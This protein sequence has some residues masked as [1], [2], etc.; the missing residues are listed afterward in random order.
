MGRIVFV[1]YD[2]KEEAS[3]F[4]AELIT[5]I[6]GLLPASKT[7]VLG[8]AT[9]QSPVLTYQEIAKIVNR[10]GH[11]WPKI[12]DTIEFWQLDTYV[13]PG[14]TEDNL[15]PYSYE[16]ELAA[17]IWKVPN[18]GC[19]IPREWAEDPESE[20]LRYA[21]EIAE[22]I[23]RVYYTFQVLG[24]GDEDGHIAF[25]MP[26]DSFKSKTHRVKL[27]KETIYANAHKFFGGDEEKV[28]KYAITTGIGEIL[29]SNAIILEAF[30]KKKANI[31]WKSFFTDPTTD[32]PATAL[33]LF[34][35]DLV[36]LLDEEAAS[37]IVEKEGE[38]VFTKCALNET[39]VEKF[40]FEYFC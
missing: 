39:D 22:R 7:K 23:R 8:T 16:R 33:Q 38:G 14:S 6:F 4:A 34:K 32:I 3:Q 5:T 2:T 29:Q 18:G 25:N 27:N 20:A 1:K 21:T 13:S 28:P 19:Y 24:I 26:G 15:P 31:V 11:W 17:S 10:P 30:G 37:T 9:G 36:V 35:G 40:C 12:A